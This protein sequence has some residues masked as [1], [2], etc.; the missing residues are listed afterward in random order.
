MDVGVGCSVRQKQDSGVRLHRNVFQ[1]I[2]KCP[3][4]VSRVLL[5]DE[6]LSKGSSFLESLGKRGSMA[7]L[8]RSRARSGN[9]ALKYH[10]RGVQFPEI[11]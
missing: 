3:F 9:N 7:F 10:R 5:S 2:T 1:M 4:V 6:L 8:T 11:L